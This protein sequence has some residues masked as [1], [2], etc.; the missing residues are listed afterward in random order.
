MSNLGS[1]HS[2]QEEPAQQSEGAQHGQYSLTTAGV[3]HPSCQAG[4]GAATR[5]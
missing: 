3:A 1:H 2:T 4:P 5:K